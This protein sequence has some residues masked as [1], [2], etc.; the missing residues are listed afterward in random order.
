MDQSEAFPREIV[1]NEMAESE[2]SEER[3]KKC[4]DDI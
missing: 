2:E 3:S 4:S 1:V